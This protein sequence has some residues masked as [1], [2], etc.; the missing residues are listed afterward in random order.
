MATLKELLDVLHEDEKLSPDGE[1]AWACKLIVRVQAMT[2]GERD[3]LRAA[4]KSGPLYDGDVPSKSARD[5][6]LE[7]GMIAKVVVKG[8]EGYNA[9]TYRGSAAYRLLAAGA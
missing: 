2:G 7:A 9:C 3:T 5:A 8:E 4:F 6:L 1:L